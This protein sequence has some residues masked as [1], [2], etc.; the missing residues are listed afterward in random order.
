MSG[1]C[2]FMSCDNGLYIRGDPLVYVPLL[3]QISLASGYIYPTKYLAIHSLA[4]LYM[5]IYTNAYFIKF[6]FCMLLPYL[7]I[8][9]HVRYMYMCGF[10]FVQI[11]IFGG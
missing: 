8:G 6:A 3:A 4:S 9:T 7:V 5:N 10:F 2:T 11:Y 1:H